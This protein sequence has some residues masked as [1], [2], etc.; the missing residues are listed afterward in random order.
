MGARTPGVLADGERGTGGA[1]RA[2]RHVGTGQ[3]CPQRAGPPSSG[4]RHRP[5][6]SRGDHHASPR[7]SIR[8]SGP[9]V[10]RR[11]RQYGE[12]RAG[13]GRWP[14]LR[15]HGARTAGPGPNGGRAAAGCADR[16][17]ASGGRG[18]LDSG[19]LPDAGPDGLAPR[20]PVRSPGLGSGQ[21]RPA[22]LQRTGPRGAL[23][24]PVQLHG[25]RTAV[26]TAP[27]RRLRARQPAGSAF[28]RV[29]GWPALHSHRPEHDRATRERLLRHGGLDA[30]TGGGGRELH[31]YLA[32]PSFLRHRAL[33]Q[34]RL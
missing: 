4:G 27:F 23:G 1:G 25:P 6:G 16:R 5:A 21:D 18:T 9:H 15:G 26:R 13:V 33:A 29:I 10:V 17:G 3:Q 14:G 20:W 2:G 31:P 34:R 11:R 24:A 12:D 19:R 28:L 30:P 32:E 22:V 7:G 8:T